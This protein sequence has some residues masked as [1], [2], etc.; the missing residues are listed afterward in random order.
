MGIRLKILLACLGMTAVTL[1]LGIYGLRQ[2]AHQ[3]Q[4]FGQL[5]ERMFDKGLISIASA[6]SARA[7]FADATASLLR[8]EKPAKLLRQ[9]VDD[10]DVVIERA[11]STDAVELAKAL[12][13]K[14]ERLDA[15]AAEAI[16][17]EFGSLTEL[18]V[19]GTFESRLSGEDYFADAARANKIAMAASVLA[20]L[21]ITWA[22]GR[23]IVPAIRRAAQIAAAIADGKL[24]NAIGA[25][26]RGE[27][28]QLMR[29]LGHMQQAIGENLQRLEDARR[30]AVERQEAHGR[31]MT[32]AL[33]EMAASIERELL[34]AVA[35]AQDSTGA[36]AGATGEMQRTAGHLHG[37]ASAVSSIAERSLA[38]TRSVADAAGELDVSVARVREQIGHASAT[39]RR[40]SDGAR[41]TQDVIE[42]LAHAAQQIEQ[43]VDLIADVANRTNLLALNATIE[44][45]R[46]GD[47]GRGF[48]VVAGEVK[49]LAQQTAKA[50]DDIRRYMAEV[51]QVK[52]DVVAAVGQISDVIGEINTASAEISTVIEQQVAV[53][54]TIARSVADSAK[55]ATAA[56]QQIAEMSG[57]VDTV[58]TLS[59]K[60]GSASTT[61]AR[62]V[63][64]LKGSI[65]AIV[66]NT[67]RD[68]AA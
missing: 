5:M 29:A 55:D 22:A 21:L 33:E 60:V 34:Q 27:T 58:K 4:Q 10:L 44:A 26:G 24:D 30:E 17:Q 56:V 52:S 45:A 15:S 57:Q 28:A 6:A 54:G 40:A 63:D 41:R 16:G 12:R 51:R 9:T 38:A 50:S 35:V 25:K 1:A 37:N 32:A 19:A 48:S 3:G 53:T 18:L 31:Q 66:R 36:M 62:Q 11:A 68:Q 20:A 67:T 46:A 65:S 23:S 8:G 39:A 49:S 14:I 59:D 64:A 13:A 7:S 43:M 61:L 42:V 2:G 47:A